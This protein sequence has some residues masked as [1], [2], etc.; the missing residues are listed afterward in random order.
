MIWGVAG[1]RPNFFS[2]GRIFLAELAQ[3]SWRDLAAEIRPSFAVTISFLALPLHFNNHI[4]FLD[5]SAFLIIPTIAYFHIA[6]FCVNIQVAKLSISCPLP[7][8]LPE[9]GKKSVW[10]CS[11]PKDSYHVEISS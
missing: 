10:L 8:P 9:V 3:K 1:W 4:S 7:P 2:S 11:P 5:N 6:L